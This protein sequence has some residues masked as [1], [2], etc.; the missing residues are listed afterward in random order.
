MTEETNTGDGLS[1]E[2]AA[3]FDSRGEADV[4]TAVETPVITETAVA[5]EQPAQTQD[6]D[7]KGKFVPHGALHAEREEHKK[8][9]SELQEIRTK[10]AVLEDR[11]NTLFKANQSQQETAVETPPNPEEDIF[12]FS[13]WQNDQ[14]KRLETKITEREQ[15][16]QQSKQQTEQEKAIWDHWNAS[17]AQFEAETPDFTRAAEYLLNLRTGQLKTIGLSEQEINETINKE[18]AGVVI[19]SANSNKSPAELVYN[20]AKASGY[21]PAQAQAAA[22]QVA[23]AT[24]LPDN[25]KRIQSAQT[26]SRTVG[27]SG[28]A[29]IDP[30]S[31]ESVLAMSEDEYAKWVSKPGNFRRLAG[32]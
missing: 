7:E 26:A 1:A 12:A 3:Y 13:K 31:V 18:V 25:L 27:A 22:A 17:R 21:T 29:G 10:Q 9:R 32:G 2:E 19:Q 23:T 6:R 15:Q 20:Y 30:D 8:T 14:L 24:E 4:T 16:E 11:W 5:E 28:G